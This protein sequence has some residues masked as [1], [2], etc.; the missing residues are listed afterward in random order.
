MVDPSMQSCSISADYKESHERSGQDLYEELPL[1][2][3]EEIY[4]TPE[5]QQWLKEVIVA[6]LSPRIYGHFVKRSDKNKHTSGISSGV[7]ASSNLGDGDA[8]L[9]A[10]QLLSETI[11]GQG[12]LFTDN[13]KGHHGGGKG[14]ASRRHRG[15]PGGVARG[16][17]EEEAVRKELNKDLTAISTLM[18]NCRAASLAVSV[19]PCTAELQKDLKEKIVQ[20]KHHQDKI[21]EMVF[22]KKC[23]VSSRDILVSY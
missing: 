10:R 18:S 15:R 21:E 8:G 20:V 6:R 4:K 12:A 5:Q 19:M 3:L 17:S 9:A 7:G 11:V 22:G 14:K 2:M 23:P 16:V 1:F 13:S